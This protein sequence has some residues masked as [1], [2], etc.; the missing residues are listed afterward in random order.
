[1]SSPLKR[2]MQTAQLLAKELRGSPGVVSAPRLAPEGAV[3]DAVALLLRGAP[4]CVVAVGHEPLLTAIAA[5]LL[6]TRRLRIDL[7]KGGVVE[8]ELE[9]P[10]NAPA[11]LLGI[12]RP[13]HGK[14]LR[15]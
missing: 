15:G 10:G 7:R 4:S 1:M 3:E 11:V 5:H 2:A 14:S 9:R 13:G 8:L 12:V 6:G